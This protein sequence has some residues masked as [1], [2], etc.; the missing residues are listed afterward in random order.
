MADVSGE[1]EAWL[2]EPLELRRVVVLASEVRNRD[3]GRTV[4]SSV[5][6]WSTM[7]IVRWTVVA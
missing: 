1:I 2:G 5:E 7:M 3:G 4:V 6:L